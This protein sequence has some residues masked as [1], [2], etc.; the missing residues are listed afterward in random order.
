MQIPIRLAQR[1]FQRA[2]VAP[3][4]LVERR[5]ELREY[6]AE[7][8]RP[9]CRDHQISQLAQA[10]DALALELARFKHHFWMGPNPDGHHQTSRIEE[11]AARFGLH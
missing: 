6:C 10:G 7:S 5:T 9:V 2:E 4:P 3:L 1:A 11:R 8:H